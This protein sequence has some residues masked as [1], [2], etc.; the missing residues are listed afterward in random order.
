VVTWQKRQLNGFEG[1]NG[2]RSSCQS[3]FQMHASISTLSSWASSKG[4]QVSKFKTFHPGSNHTATVHIMY[5]CR[6]VSCHLLDAWDDAHCGK[7]DVARP[8]AKQAQSKQLGTD[9]LQAQL[10]PKPPTLAN[11]TAPVHTAYTYRQVS[12]QLLD[13]WDDAHCGHRDVARPNAKQARVSHHA[14]CSLHCFVVAQRLPHALQGSPS[15]IIEDVMFGH[16][17]WASNRSDHDMT[18]D[19]QCHVGGQCCFSHEWRAV[20]YH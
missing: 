18:A 1:S 15:F 5:T 6:Q 20:Q 16:K 10:E 8:D 13:A 9:F 19:C 2:L 14:H 11:T 7:C 17:N 12:C 3:A 4:T